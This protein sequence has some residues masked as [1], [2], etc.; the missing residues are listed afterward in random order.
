MKIETG[1]H[2]PIKNRP[3]R[4]PLNKRQII[5]K[6][7]LE[8]MD[9]KIIERSQS[10]WSFP[11]VVVKKKDGS[12]RMCVDFRSLNKIVKPVS[13]PLPLIDDILSLL[14]LK[15]PVR[16]KIPCLPLSS[17]VFSLSSP[18]HPLCATVQ[19]PCIPCHPLC[20]P[21]HNPCVPL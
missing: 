8:M 18:I 20:T 11:L 16:M 6:A 2:Q 21:V 3:Y 10:P 9:A 4:V 15:T 17:P 5:D 13:F 19:S 7:I 1:D 14:D 12:D